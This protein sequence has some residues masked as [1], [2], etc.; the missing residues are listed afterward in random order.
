MVD[1]HLEWNKNSS[2]IAL[3]KREFKELQ[4]AGYTMV[5][6]GKLVKKWD[7]ALESVIATMDPGPLLTPEPEPEPK[8]TKAEAKKEAAADKKAD[9]AAKKEA[10][11]DAKSK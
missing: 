10:K 11:A 4:A 3:A 8:L 9:A 5:K 2:Q 6:D 1:K 7:P